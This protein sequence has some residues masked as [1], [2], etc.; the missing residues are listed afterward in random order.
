VNIL[1]S[2]GWA[3]YMYAC[4]RG[5]VGKHAGDQP[6][7]MP[8]KACRLAGDQPEG[9]LTGGARACMRGCVAGQACGLAGGL[10]VAWL[11]V[12]IA[13]PAGVP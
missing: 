12:C 3:P 2:P 5:C 4:M 9:M 11:R 7:G 1:N 8:P 10:L 6:K 13:K